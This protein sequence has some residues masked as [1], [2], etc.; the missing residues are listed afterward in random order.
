M[1]SHKDARLRELQFLGKVERA[2]SLEIACTQDLDEADRSMLVELIYAGYVNGVGSPPWISE[3][4]D[5]PAWET[6][7]PR[8]NIIWQQIEH[9]RWY[10]MNRVQGGRDVSLRM[11]HKGRVRL[12][13]LEQALKTGR[14]RDPTGI[15]ISRRHLEKDLNIALVSAAPE[16]PVAVCMLDLNGLKQINDSLGH[17]AGDA[18]I[19]TYLKSVAMFFGDGAEGYRADGGDELFVVMQG[20]ALDHAF[21]TI[22][23]ALTQLAKERVEGVPFLSASC[24]LIVT[25]DPNA[26][27]KDLIKR[28]DAIQYRAKNESKKHSPR[29]SVMAVNDEAVDILPQVRAEACS[30]D[31]MDTGPR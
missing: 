21:K 29:P 22:R 1:P 10:W 8:K 11:A 28:V 6:L 7:D 26:D 14:D 16:S 17:A 23:Q 25:G 19:A 24:G 27:A 4:H 18:A 12:S 15:M 13:E 5:L 3:T 9:Q 30:L 2:G 31:R 20:A